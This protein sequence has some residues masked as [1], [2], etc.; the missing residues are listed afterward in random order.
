[1]GPRGTL[2]GMDVS[3]RATIRNEFGRDLDIAPEHASIRAVAE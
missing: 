2:V 3:G 1:M